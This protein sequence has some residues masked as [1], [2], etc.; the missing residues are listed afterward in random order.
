VDAI[1]KFN[2]PALNQEDSVAALIIR[3]TE[4]LRYPAN[5]AFNDE[6]CRIRAILRSHP[7]LKQ[8]LPEFLRECRT[9]ADYREFMRQRHQKEFEWD[10][11][12]GNALLQLYERL[13]S[14]SSL[15]AYEIL[16]ELGCGGFGRV[17]LA[18][19]NF[20]DRRFAIKFFQPAFHQGGGS[21][22]SR[23]YQEASMLFDLH[24]PNIVSV[25]DV[26]MYQER[27]FIVMDYFD[28]I[29]LNSALSQHGR[30]PP[31]KAVAM[32]EMVA[33][34]VR[35]AHELNIVHRDLKPGNIMLRP[36]TCRVIDFGLGVYVEQAL[37]SRLTRTGEGV[38]GG[39]YTARELFANPKLV[40][41]RCDV[42]SIGAV[43]YTAVTNLVPAGANIESALT[44]VEELPESHRVIIMRCLSDA[45]SRFESC[46]DLLQALH[47]STEPEN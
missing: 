32:I 45:E 35:H 9:I 15:D 46:A 6:Y 10:A 3:L 19:H 31:E 33:N 5:D 7:L 41:P 12:S 17:F 13:Q 36:S 4:E 23:F 21:A 24:H 25:R 2:L 40:D 20:L 34:A 39:H 11:H 28:G 44:K 43:W 14:A 18:R 38:A 22:I 30:M 37:A 42:Y 1:R 29:T 16:D 27:P 47:A 26:G 8:H